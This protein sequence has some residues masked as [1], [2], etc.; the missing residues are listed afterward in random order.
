MIAGWN[1]VNDGELLTAE[2]HAKNFRNVSMKSIHHHVWGTAAPD[3]TV[4]E[5]L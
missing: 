3:T 5:N 4:V 2:I 1:L